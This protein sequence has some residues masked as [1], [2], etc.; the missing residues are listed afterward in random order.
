VGWSYSTNGEKRNV[1]RSLVGDRERRRTLGRGRRR[2]VDNIKTDR[3]ECCG[4]DWYGS[5]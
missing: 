5:G 2:W 3:I 4:L 1:Y